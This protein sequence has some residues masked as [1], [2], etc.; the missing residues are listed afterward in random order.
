MSLPALSWD[1]GPK[2]QTESMLVGK[3]LRGFKD[4]RLLLV[5]GGWLET[6]PGGRCR[7]PWGSSL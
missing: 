3:P 6:R 2:P 4:P 7:R 1:L 5:P